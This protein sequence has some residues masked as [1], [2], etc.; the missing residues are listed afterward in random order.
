MLGMYD[1]P[2]LQLANDRFWTLIRDRLGFGPN[3]LTRDADFWEVWRHPELIFA[4]TCGMPYRTNL[5]GNVQLVGTP[6]YG[7]AG[8]PPGYYRSVFVTRQ[9]D[10][11][12]LAQLATGTFAYNEKLSQSGWAAPLVHLEGH[13][14]KPGAF[15]A[16]GSHAQSANAVAEGRADIAALDALTWE[17]LKAHT[18]LGAVLREAGAT[19]PTPALPYITAKGQDADAIAG[20]VRAAIG[21]LSPSDRALLHLRGLIDIPA[22]DYLSV[23]N[24]SQ[25]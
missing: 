14:Q 20:A 19:A 10:P 1:M 6:D 13:N 5:H 25:V 7:L 11:R 23:P 22:N 17:L 21:D 3:H 2:A 16:T 15:L 18:N 8:C 9:D 24:P 4:Q 12:V